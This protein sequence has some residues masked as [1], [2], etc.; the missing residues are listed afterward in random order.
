MEH[1]IIINCTTEFPK[2]NQNKE[3]LYRVIYFQFQI[4]Y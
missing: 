2:R 4:L 1:F 3:N